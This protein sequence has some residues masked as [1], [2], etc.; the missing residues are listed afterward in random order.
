MIITKDLRAM[1][2]IAGL[3]TQ[4]DFF[5]I[6]AAKSWPLVTENSTMDTSKV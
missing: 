5:S 1:L 3:P 6:K 2:R 4:N